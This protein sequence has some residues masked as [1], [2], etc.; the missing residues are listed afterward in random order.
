MKNLKLLTGILIAFFGLYLCSC[1]PSKI[2]E[3]INETGD[4]AGQAIGELATGI[5]TGVKKSI[6]PQVELSEKL[7]TDGISL[8]KIL[9]SG[10]S[11]EVENIVTAY[12]IFNANFKQ[13]LTVKAFDKKQLE[14]GRVRIEVEGKKDEAKYVEFHFDKR[15]DIDNDSKVTIE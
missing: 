15:T 10:D 4:A 13:H 12:I 9:V 14:M 1:S 7:K 11:T 3:K 5:T 6:Q 2:K 8:G